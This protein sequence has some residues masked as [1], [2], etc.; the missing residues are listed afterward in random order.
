[1]S[2]VNSFSNSAN[3]LLYKVEKSM[4]SQIPQ[5]LQQILKFMILVKIYD[6]CLKANTV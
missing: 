6:S 2:P 5:V 1:M 3:S 4:L